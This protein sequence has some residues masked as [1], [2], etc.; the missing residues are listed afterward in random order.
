M[1]YSQ[2]I[3]ASIMEASPYEANVSVKSKK[4][5]RPLFTPK[6]YVTGK[7]TP[8]KVQKPGYLK[9][10]LKGSVGGAVVGSLGGI[11][12]S[13]A[14]PKHYPGGKKGVAIGAGIGAGLGM[15]S[16]TGEIRR[17]RKEMKNVIAAVQKSGGKPISHKEYKILKQKQLENKVQYL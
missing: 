4:A 7:G 11:I 15:L 8:F 5:R 13:A 6:H 16:K 17:R 3:L 10:S 14:V 12:G 1:R 9:D 2:D